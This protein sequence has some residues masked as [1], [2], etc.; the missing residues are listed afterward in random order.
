MRRVPTP[1]RAAGEGRRRNGGVRGLFHQPD[2]RV[3]GFRHHRYETTVD[4]QS[5][6]FGVA[7]DEC[8]VDVL[9][10]RI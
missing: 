10:T 5:H 3:L 6:E 2:R 4:D 9:H 8:A 1:D 7:L